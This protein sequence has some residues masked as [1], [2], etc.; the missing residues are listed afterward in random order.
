MDGNAQSQEYEVRLDVT[1]PAD[2]T[3]VFD[4]GRFQLRSFLSRMSVAGFPTAKIRAPLYTL[5]VRTEPQ[6]ANV[7]R[8]QLRALGVTEVNTNTGAPSALPDE[9]SSNAPTSNLTT[10]TSSNRAAFLHLSIVVNILFG[11]LALLAITFA[12]YGCF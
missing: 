12:D 8:E 1:K 6:T 11:V 7:I 10:W 5:R 4:H 2:L 3:D 9:T